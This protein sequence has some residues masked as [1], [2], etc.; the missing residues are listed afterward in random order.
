MKRRHNLSEDELLRFAKSYLSEAF[1]NPERQ[2]CPADA[3]LR[4]LAEKPREADPAV[5]EHISFCS[6]CF[7]RYMEL[8]EEQKR[9]LRSSGLRKFV[10]RR[11]GLMWAAA[12]AVVL[13][14][15]GAA[16]IAT[17]GLPWSSQPHYSDFVVDLTGASPL[18]GAEKQPPLQDLEI[19]RSPLN[20]IVLLPVGSE[21]GPYQLTLRSGGSVVWSE[22]VTARLIE[23]VVKANA[24]V[25]LRRFAPGRYLLTV[26]SNDE[27]RFSRPIL[28]AESGTSTTGAEQPGWGSQFLFSMASGLMSLR[29]PFQGG[30]K[31]NVAP[32]S[33]DAE[34]LLAEADRLA[35]LANR[36]AAGP[37]YARAEALGKTPNDPMTIHARVGRIR[38]QAESMPF[39]EVSNLLGAELA[40]TEVQRNARLRLFVLTA[41]GYTDLD[42]NLAS[43]REAWEQ[44]LE[45]SRQLNDK[46][47]EARASGELGIVA[48]LE[49]DVNRATKLIGSALLSAMT[50]GD[51]A[52]QVRFL[53]MIGNGFADLKRYEEASEFFTRALNLAKATEDIGFPF[54]AYEG[55]ARSLTAMGKTTEA[56]KLLDSALQE[57]KRLDKRGHQA[58]ILILLGDLAVANKNVPEAIKYF[59]SAA[60]LSRI[61]QFRRMEAEAM[62]NLAT[63][64]R[65][66][67]DL[68][69]TERSLQ[70]GID[71]SQA[72]GDTYYLPRDL[73]SLAE[74]KAIRGDIQGADALWEQAT[75]V[76]EG[77]LVNAPGAYARSTLV[78]VMSDIYVRHFLATAQQNNV[79]RAFRIVE[80]ARGRSIADLMGH[81]E[82]TRRPAPIQVSLERQIATLQ[83]ALLRSN[84]PGER[85]QLLEQLFETERRRALALSGHPNRYNVRRPVTLRN[86]Q[87]SL[88]PDE[89]MLEY[90]LADPASYCIALTRE[91]A[92]LIKLPSS[93]QHVEALVSD[94]LSQVRS[95]KSAEERATDLHAVLLAPADAFRSKSRVIVVPDGVLHLLPFDALKTPGGEYVLESR[96]VTYAP[97][98]SVLH[99]LRTSRNGTK[100][101]LPFLGLGD[102]RYGLDSPGEAN[103]S[104]GGGER[105]TRGIYDLAGARFERLPG[106]R[107]EVL[108]ASHI[109]GS[110]S[111]ALLDS[112]AT[113]D[114][115]K[116]Q[117]LDNFR[118]IHLA[119]HGFSSPKHPDRA[120]LVLGRTSE[121]DEDGLLQ[122]R[123]IS[124]LALNADLVALSAC[125][126]GVGRLQGAEGIANLQR[127][128]LVAGARTTV[129]TLWKAD[130]TFTAA[131]IKQFYRNL[132]DGKDK[133]SA[134]AQAKLALLAKFGDQAL[135]F[136]WAG[137]VMD[138]E[139]SSPIIQRR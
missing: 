111:V 115:F 13:I 116:N 36:P 129:A 100:T 64:Y 24:R 2:G 16:L 48:F 125:D 50:N 14:S 31:K 5:S 9:L 51:A 40:R 106:T 43:C 120:A 105:A 98:A 96:V 54:M 63:I 88:Q 133:G 22:G 39:A 130:D 55:Q 127:A 61:S 97:S 95:R 139:S 33:S 103:E 121:S 81:R 19:P 18:R 67:G 79:G 37:L 91:S 46:Q 124:E 123:E 34:Q 74:I 134:L 1:P 93:R 90:V 131:L 29:L 30:G 122:T 28:L 137:F 3:E 52:A 65:K 102:V 60:E 7:V 4:R 73:A 80:R 99:Q 25:D 82:A 69:Q 38:S 109:F 32:D 92:R 71:A 53:S 86:V 132:A 113:E 119:V 85:G 41:K 118:V 35:W 83:V 126:T 27:I 136:Y 59:D 42:V 21:E 15:V 78:A 45:L 23:R 87:Q 104:K 108:N 101:K 6:P 128:F 75:D 26:D 68:P 62:Y 12:A 58:Q 49:G 10:P 138:G 57:A 72:V 107:D 47:W 135:P 112:K 94:Y 117:P 114:M 70:R 44:A 11:R 20:L 89:L 8:L 77:M 17:R 66:Q 56:K 84:D 76:L 110:G